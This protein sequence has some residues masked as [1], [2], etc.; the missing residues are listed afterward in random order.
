MQTAKLQGTRRI[1]RRPCLIR[2]LA[3]RVDMAFTAIQEWFEGEDKL[4]SKAVGYGVVIL[5]GVYMVGQI[6]RWLL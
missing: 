1:V 4:V 2:Q 6:V 3:R 5:A